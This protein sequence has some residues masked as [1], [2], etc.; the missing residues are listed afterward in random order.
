MLGLFSAESIM[1]DVCNEA[2]LAILAQ[3]QFNNAAL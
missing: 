2:V 3:S 1:Q